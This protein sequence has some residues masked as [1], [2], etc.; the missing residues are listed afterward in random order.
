[1]EIA[2]GGAPETR[3]LPRAAR[4]EVGALAEVDELI[5]SLQGSMQQELE[6]VEQDNHRARAILHFELGHLQELVFRESEKALQLYEEAFAVDPGFVPAIRALRRR[7]R[8][9]KRWKETLKA[10]EAE[11]AVTADEEERSNLLVEMG[12]LLVSRFSDTEAAIKC[13]KAATRLV[14]SQRRAAELL[15]DIYTRLEQWDDLLEVL[16]GIANVT[17]DAVERAR[18]LS[19]MAAVCEYHLGRAT[20]AE[21]LYTQALDLDPSSEGATVALRRLY[22]AHGRW[23]DLRDLLAQEAGRDHEPDE[24]FADLYRAARISEIHLQDDLQAASL[25]ETAA[26]LRPGDPLPLQALTAIYQRTGRHEDQ[27][28]ALARQLRLVRDPHE[29]AALCYRLGR[30]QEDWLDRPED[31]LRSYRDAL[32]EQPGHEA[33][34]RALAS[35]YETFE[36]WE[37]LLDLELLRAERSR[38]VARRA[39]GYV[40]AARISEWQVHDLRRAVDLYDRAYGMVAGLPEA[41]R[42][43]ERIYRGSER[44]EPLAELYEREADATKDSALAV[45]LLRAAGRLHEQSLG[46]RERAIKTLERLLERCPDDRETVIHLSRLYEESGRVDDLRRLLEKWAAATEDEQLQTELRRRVGE[47]LE[48]PLRRT[49]QA[50]DVYRGILERVP[51]D[52]PTMERLKAIF[53][54]SGRWTD[55]VDL[56]RA[57]QRAVGDR[58]EAAPLLLQIGQICRDKLGDVEAAQAAFKE[59][60]DADQ[61]N[62]PALQALMELLEE[63][64]L[65]ERLVK[66]LGALAERTKE[67]VRAAAV[68]C[69]AA[70]VCEER[71]REASR[72][73]EFY[74]RALELDPG[75]GPARHGLERLYQASGDRAALE[76]HYLREAEG[77]TNPT[78]RL[79]AYLRLGALFSGIGNDPVGA[80]AA[81][82]SALRVVE[83]Q[84]DA[85]RSLAAIHRQTMSWDRLA[86]VLARVAGT[87]AEPLAAV[88]ALKEWAA[89]VERH[90]SEQWDPAPI[91]E[92]ILDGLPFDRQALF[93][94]DGIAYARGAAEVLASLARRQVQAGGDPDLIASL[95]T[96]AAV[97]DLVRGEV[98]QAAEVL[99]RGL[100][101]QP[102]YLPAVQLLRQ[103]DETLEEWGEAAELMLREGDLLSSPELARAA[104]VRAG[105]ILL[106][107]F[108]DVARARGAFERVFTED[109]TNA[110][111][112]GRLAAILSASQEWNALV[113]AYRRRMETMDPPSRIPLQLELAS[114]YRDSLRDTGAAI[115]VLRDLLEVDDSHRRGLTEIAELCVMQGR[116]RE[117]EGYLDR[118]ARACRNEDAPAARTAL[119]QRAQVLEEQL[120]DEEQGLRVLQALL[121]DHPGDEEALARCLQVHQ[122]RGDWE[123]AVEVLEEL[124]RSGPAARRINNLVNLAELNSRTVHDESK[125]GFALTRAAKICVESGEGVDRITDYFERRGDFEGLVRL[126]GEALEELPPEGSP[127]SVN[128]RLARAR[129]LAGRLLQPT[130][131]E[132]E[133]RRALQSE[134]SSIPARLELAGLHLWG[135]NLGEA[136]SEYMRILEQDP[137]STEAYRGLYRVYD[138]RGDMERAA[139]AAQ[140]VAAVAG[141]DV[142]E[143]KIAAQA[144]A[145]MEAALSSAVATP[146]GVHDYWN[147]LAHPDEPQLAREL[148]YLV[149]DFIPAVVPHEVEAA[150]GGLIPLSPDDSLAGRCGQLGQVMGVER[151]E[152]CLGRNRVDGVA[153]LPGTPPRLVV[154]ES[155]AQRSSA[156]EFRFAVGR[157]LADVLAR[158]LYL[159]A[160][161]ARTVELLL[162]AVATL[163]ERSY[164][165][166]LNQARD[167]EELTRALGR[168]IPRKVRKMLEEPGR[169][170]AAAQPV[171]FKTWY[172]ASQRSAERA[173]LLLSGD[174]EAALN[175]LRREKASRAVQAELLRF[176]VGPHL[177]EARRR[178]GLS[179]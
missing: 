49:E 21:D 171:I 83:D 48:G 152:V 137:F 145:P 53:E 133:I 175:V 13:L 94:L 167:V 112:F 70:E 107:R 75:N 46:N 67:P 156:G 134:P 104:L 169:A 25:L 37:D 68:L 172:A 121:V 44:W 51:A 127:G 65:W 103:L 119:L 116:W 20:E 60:F 84:P 170:Y 12:E 125:A 81:Y 47:L 153:A 71:L 179:I 115:D 165:E 173:G 76:A 29:R 87:S 35:L 155:F 100:Q 108:G 135:D 58:S 99:R 126:F 19:E 128:V 52:R 177:Y 132:L 80:A 34:L 106:D 33:S 109:P 139:G 32:K 28:A 88:S 15:R 92:R 136:T 43:L 117:A 166:Y 42:A 27:A 148:L 24:R 9:D 160:L 141:K 63:Q 114:L 3:R 56:L 150:S 120:G 123:Q 89:I 69:A 144:T 4:Q 10:L 57:E 124:A 59:A 101:N 16:R 45:S 14:P 17:A 154:D 36:R 6:R 176:T 146:L 98:Q 86:A 147:L 2:P 5:T 102:D 66:L 149:A 174:V 161:Q 158:T 122:R 111:A 159:H 74:T 130:E 31:A 55:L 77:T 131:A 40:R 79:R 41:F 61:G 23:K 85:M 164:G 143:R 8:Q 64:G 97:L 18:L 142:P 73:E 91:Y 110:A 90:L 163:F 22:L 95:C 96:R 105:N 129:I 151:I 118:L 113:A 11:S 162:A 62:T 1:M 38:D 54:R 168:A 78:L 26:A 30:V 7:Y 50:V 157:A 138:R 82:E 178:L 140:A 39:D 93:A 72:A